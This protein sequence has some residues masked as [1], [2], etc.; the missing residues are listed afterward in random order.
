MTSNVRPEKHAGRRGR[1]SDRGP[2]ATGK[3]DD[4]PTGPSPHDRMRPDH[5]W[6]NGVAHVRCAGAVSGRLVAILAKVG[7]VM[8]IFV[9]AVFVLPSMYTGFWLRGLAA[10]REVREAYTHGWNAAM[11]QKQ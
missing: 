4:V 8:L 2:A 7:L 6:R 9:V 10:K 1:H 11:G 3:A 5:P